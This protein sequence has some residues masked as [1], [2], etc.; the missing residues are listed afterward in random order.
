[1]QAIDNNRLENCIR[2]FVL[3]RKARLFSEPSAGAHASAGLYS[4]VESARPRT[5][6]PTAIYDTSSQPYPQRPTLNTSRRCCRG[7]WIAPSSPASS[8]P[9]SNRSPPAEFTAPARGTSWIANG[10]A[11]VSVAVQAGETVTGRVPDTINAGEGRSVALPDPVMNC[12]CMN[13]SSQIVRGNSE[14]LRSWC[15]CV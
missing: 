10:R 5:S 13:V 14:G 11:C 8:G 9:A 1:M 2:P 15:G 3:G 4:L 12:R 6:N 7:T